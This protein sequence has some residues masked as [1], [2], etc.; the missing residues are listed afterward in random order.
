MRRQGFDFAEIVVP[1]AAARRQWWESGVKNDFTDGFFLIGHG[2]P[3]EEPY[4]DM[5]YLWDH[6]L[7]TLMATVDTASRLQIGQLTVH[8]LM[9]RRLVGPLILVEKIR[10]LKALVQYG[11]K[12]GV[13][14]CM[15]NLS[16][17]ADDLDA[18]LN[19]VPDL[20]VTLDVGHAHLSCEVNRSY[21]IIKRFGKRI[22]HVHLHDNHGGDI[23]ADDL[24]LSI[25]EGTIDFPAILGELLHSGYR[26]T[27]T[28][29]VNLQD[30]LLSRDRIRTLIAGLLRKD[31][32]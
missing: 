18:V 25:E 23:F 31:A 14:V 3:V 11:Q 28:I 7:P 19:A 15:E 4:D 26:G 16:E 27:M 10:A 9:D 20:R 21:E 29:E 24:H 30:L 12:C 22:G 1:N 8:M 2:P 17:S 5:A 32:S 6:Y 13:I